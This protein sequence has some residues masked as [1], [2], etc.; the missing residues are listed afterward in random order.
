MVQKMPRQYQMIIFHKA[1]QDHFLITGLGPGIWKLTPLEIT[2]NG[3]Y[4]NLQQND[5]KK[6]ESITTQELLL[7]YYKTGVEV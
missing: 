2:Y 4:F 5:N 3:T 1:T 7:N 6:L